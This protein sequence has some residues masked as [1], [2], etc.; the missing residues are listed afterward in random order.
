MPFVNR[1]HRVDEPSHQ[2]VRRTDHSHTQATRKAQNNSDHSSIQ[3]AH[4]HDFIDTCLDFLADVGGIPG[5]LNVCVSFLS[6]KVKEL[7]SFIKGLLSPSEK[8]KSEERAV[9]RVRP[10]LTT[11]E[12]KQEIIKLYNQGSTID[13]IAA[14]TGN[15]VAIVRAVIVMQLRESGHSVEEIAA[16]LG[17]L[18]STIQ[19]VI[20]QLETT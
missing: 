7:S 6:T 19:D 9:E 3:T 2:P 12:D 8:P 20:D 18:P 5:M 15:Y 10:Q 11:P 4:E 14:Q 13:V 16:Q 17:L 1:T